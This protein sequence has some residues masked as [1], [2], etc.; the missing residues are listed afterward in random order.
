[1]AQYQKY[2]EQDLTKP[3][4]I[5]RDN[6]IVFNADADSVVITVTVKDN[7]SAATLSGT[8]D[9]SVIRANGTTVPLEAAI[10]GNTVTMTLSGACFAVPGDIGVGMRVISG[11]VKTTVLKVI[12]NVEMYTT[13]DV[14][15]PSGE[16][17]IDVEYLVNQIN[18]AV[19]SIPPEYTDLM[20]SIAPNFSALTA[21]TSGQ[22]VW[23]NGNLYKFTT[24]H[25]AGA[26]D[27]A[28]VEQA[29]LADDVAELYGMFSGD[30][31]DA[32]DDWLDAHPEAT[33]TVQDGAVTYSKLD[34]S[35][36]TAIDEVS[37]LDTALTAL[38]GKVDALSAGRN[39]N[40]GYRWHVDCVNG[41]DSDTGASGHAWKTLDKFFSMANNLSG[42]RADIR[43]Y[44]DTAGTY[45]VSCDANTS[46]VFTGVAIHITGGSDSGAVYDGQYIIR[47]LTTLTVKWYASHLNLRNVRIEC[48][49][50]TSDTP[51]AFDGGNYSISQCYINTQLDVYGSST[52]ISNT[53]VKNISISSGANVCAYQMKTLL[54][55]GNQI[56]VT[57]GSKLVYGGS[58]VNGN[59]IADS[60]YPAFSLNVS[61]LF[62]VQG[63]PSSLGPSVTASNSWIF[64]TSSRASS[65]QSAAGTVTDTVWVTS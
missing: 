29:V 10:S 44:L 55:T 61:E 1:M 25:S 32:V 5:R 12:Y 26:W 17:V 46:M 7:G 54:T 53:T 16:I 13:T 50:T 18:T 34:S 38:D 4:K 40:I 58:I 6:D 9:G 3:I 52:S 14:V 33:T 39:N 35:L 56:V 45:D 28:H 21:Y 37:T 8:A 57:M 30:V 42:G 59:L 48:P 64:A 51:F 23:Y 43:C 27:I 62:I 22:Y 41:D 19:S 20:A 2:Y 47:F 15:D 36:K 11:D 63:Y 65:W 24:D 31:A 60:T 49:N